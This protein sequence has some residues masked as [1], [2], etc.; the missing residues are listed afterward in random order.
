M[1]T[2]AK[3]GYVRPDSGDDSRDLV[4]QHSW[5]WNNVVSREQQV[6]MTKT[7][8]LH[9][10]QNFAANWRRDIDVFKFESAS[11]RVNNK[12]FHIAGQ[13]RSRLRPDFFTATSCQI[14]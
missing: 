7:G 12:C 2:N 10:D 8:C 3:L 6:G 11:E 9:I 5:Y 13:S 4:A 1:I 14:V